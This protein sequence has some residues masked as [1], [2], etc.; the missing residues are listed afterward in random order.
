MELPLGSDLARL[1]RVWRALIDHRLKPLE[2]T[3]THWV[4]LHY[5]YHLPPGQSQIQLAKAI[6]IEQPS[7][8]RTLDQ[9]EDKGL[10]TRH[11]CSHDRRAKRIVL[12]DAAEP[13]M[14]AVNGVI[15][16]TRNE[17]LFGITPEQVDELA[18]LISRLEHNI[19]ALHE[20]QTTES[21]P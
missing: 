18:L 6:G 3:Q 8:V 14:K 21:Q 20:S 2:L 9:L 4:T 10:I 19:L 15:N 12:T 13:I 7:L 5:I 11:I 17:I 16:H 1:V